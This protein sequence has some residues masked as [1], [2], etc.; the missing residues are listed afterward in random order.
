FTT[1]QVKEPAPKAMAPVSPSPMQADMFAVDEAS[2]LKEAIAAV[3][4]DNTTPLEAL[5][6]L[7]KLKSGL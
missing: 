5:N 1:P 2:Q 7:H 6:L 3:D 4:I